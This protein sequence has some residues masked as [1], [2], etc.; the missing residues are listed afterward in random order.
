MPIT[1]YKCSKCKMIRESYEEAERCEQ[2]HL[3]A[4]CV[5]ELEHR[6]GAYPSR[7]MLAFPDGKEREYVVAD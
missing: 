2:S 1:F 4:V 6:L 5:K 7:V 3:S